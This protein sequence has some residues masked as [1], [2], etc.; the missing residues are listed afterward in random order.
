[1]R[2]HLLS[3]DVCRLQPAFRQPAAV[4]CALYRGQAAET[5]E[6]G[7]SEHGARSA[8]WEKW[9]G[10]LHVSTTCSSPF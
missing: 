5:P 9:K 10:L 6:G 7:V 8:E 4:P 1:M 3:D 2:N